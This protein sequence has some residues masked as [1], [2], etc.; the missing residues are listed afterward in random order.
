[1]GQPR[2]HAAGRS[3][4]STLTSLPR[5]ASEAALGLAA[6]WHNSSELRR[7]K[8]PILWNEGTTRSILCILDKTAEGCRRERAGR[9][10]WP[11]K[12]SQNLTSADHLLIQR[13]RET[14]AEANRS[15]ITR[16]KAYLEI[17]EEFPELHWA[18][19]AHL[20]SR[21]AGWN[22]TDLKG[23]LMSD[24]TDT[25]FKMNMYRFLERC[26]ALIFQDAYP[27]LLLYKHSRALERSC[28]HLLQHFQISEFMI[29]FWDRFW[30][31]RSSSL[32][33]V[34]LIIN[35]QNY[36]EDR[37][38]RH[39]FFR[40]HVLNH[41]YVKLHEWTRLNQ[42]LFPLGE[43]NCRH[44]LYKQSILP[45]RPLTG[46]TIQHFADPSARIK[47]GKTLYAMLFGY[48][49]VFQGALH[50]ARCTPHQG[51]RDEYW[52]DLFTHV[53]EQAINAPDESSVLLQSEWLPEGERL[54]SPRLEQVWYD[55]EYEPIP[56]YDWFQKPDML[57][58]VSKPA[59]PLWIDM[60][61]AHRFS[62]ERTSAV[63]DAA[64]SF[65]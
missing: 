60:T 27:Q 65:R 62:L 54:Y 28:F 7:V 42:I 46:L 55:T 10:G 61:H 17:Y 3:L 15:N 5:A 26:N 53:Q 64:R 52:P 1:M 44:D 38:I 57:R 9:T 35:E 63:H 56:R 20:V 37:V 34:A 4:W 14:S 36:I 11:S 41:R 48:E 29:P 45:L 43:S 30:I 47:T 6:S 24:L 2:R 21:N 32:L 19:L 51:S 39:P 22:M 31:D 13:I 49:S 16:T 40:E 33:S 25:R 8:K 58:H 23:G 50:F 12:A 18:L 59:L